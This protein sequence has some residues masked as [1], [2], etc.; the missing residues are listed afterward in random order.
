MDIDGASV[1]LRPGMSVTAEINTGTR[2]VIDYLLSPILGTV[3][4][5]LRER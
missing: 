4:E 2:R 5:G 3:Q 1:A